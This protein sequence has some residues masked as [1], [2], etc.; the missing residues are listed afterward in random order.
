MSQSLADG[1]RPDNRPAGGNRG[2]RASVGYDVDDE[3]PTE[4][5]TSP[6]SPATRWAAA[7]TRITL[8]RAYGHPSVR[9]RAR[10]RLRDQLG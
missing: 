6:S 2:A 5:G 1:H 9:R 3:Q 4:A 10:R 7:R 8:A